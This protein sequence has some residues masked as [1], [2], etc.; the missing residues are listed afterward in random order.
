MPTF[1]C[2]DRGPCL[3][4]CLLEEAFRRRMRDFEPPP[5]GDNLLSPCG[6]HRLCHW[7]VGDEGKL[8]EI[9]KRLLGGDDGSTPETIVRSAIET[10]NADRGFV[11]VREGE[12]FEPRFHVRFDRAAVSAEERRF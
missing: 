1:V 2:D 11:V 4:P 12:S 7:L 9:A 3:A 5:R 10:A 8:L 6:G